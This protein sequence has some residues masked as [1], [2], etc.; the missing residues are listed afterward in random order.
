MAETFTSNTAVVA[1]QATRNYLIRA[2]S[3]SFNAIG[4]WKKFFFAL[5]L[6][7]IGKE[8]FHASPAKLLCSLLMKNNGNEDNAAAAHN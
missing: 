5:K 7:E 2:L 1:H 6:H 3:L 4:E 8:N